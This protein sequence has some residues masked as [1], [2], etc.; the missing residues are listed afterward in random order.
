MIVP[1]TDYV[2]IKII[3]VIN[4]VQCTFMYIMY[5]R[6]TIIGQIFNDFNLCFLISQPT[7]VLYKQKITFW[8]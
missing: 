4:A 7:L 2:I 3:I 6:K 8:V 5:V 1:H